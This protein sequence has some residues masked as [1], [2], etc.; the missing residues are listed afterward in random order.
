MTSRTRVYL[1]RAVCL[2]TAM[3]L[4]EGVGARQGTPQNPPPNPGPPPAVAAALGGSQEAAADD[5]K[6]LME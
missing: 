1:G 4:S 6:V 3:A 2:A 5:G